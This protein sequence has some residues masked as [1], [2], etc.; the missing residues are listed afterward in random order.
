MELNFIKDLFCKGYFMV[1]NENSYQ[2]EQIYFIENKIESNKNKKKYHKFNNFLRKNNYKNNKKLYFD[3]N[4]KNKQKFSQNTL[5]TKKENNEKKITKNF[6]QALSQEEYEIFSFLRSKTG[7]N[8]KKFWEN[9]DIILKEKDFSFIKNNNF[10]LLSYAILHDCT[11]VFDKLLKKFGSHLSQEEFQ[12]SIL[13]F[14]IHKNPEIINSVLN[15]YNNNYQIEESFLKQFIINIAQ[16]SYRQET[17]NLILNWL[18]PK[19]N[20]E[21]L[22][23]F[24]TN[25]IK[26]INIPIIMHSLKISLYAKY[27]NKNLNLYENS[28]KSIGRLNEIKYILNEFKKLKKIDNLN[29]FNI[30]KENNTFKENNFETTILVSDKVEQFKVIQE[31]LIDKK[32][33]KIILKKKRKL[34]KI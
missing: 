4:L 26:N 32:P 29:Q 33:I 8:E 10:S 27:L 21:L 12:N 23:I 5:I 34:N 18:I 22:D 30:I 6:E 15:F 7:Y 31:N 20:D 13:K 16:F 1:N 19:L 28:L 11:I 24:W 9:L 14:C 17:N 25:A 2:N 3:I